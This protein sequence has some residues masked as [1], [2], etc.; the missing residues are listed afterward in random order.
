MDIV[1]QLILP[2]GSVLLLLILGL[3]AR[4]VFT[5][6][7]GNI[8]IAAGLLMLFLLSLWPVAGELARPLQ[9]ILP[10]SQAQ[11]KSS[12]AGAI[13]ILSAGRNRGL[14]YGGE[15]IDETTLA[16]VR[17]GA[18]LYQRSKLPVL[19]T[20]GVVHSR[21]QPLAALMKTALEREFAT[22]V[23]WVEANSNTTYENAL[24]SARILQAANIEHILLVTHAMHMRRSVAAFE[25]MG[26]KVTPAPT[27]YEYMTG[28]PPDQVN[29]Y[30]PNASAL[31]ASTEALHE[32]FG[33]LWYWL[34]Y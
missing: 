5:G 31:N 33:L 12:E 22:P 24:Y 6:W 3:I 29:D 30:F 23:R 18:W 1:E 21:G 14:E 19:V 32:W 15:V 8:M 26:I 27:M 9:N 25:K 34:R 11:L 7:L 13:V 28:F 4:R 17:Y 10:L 20:G 2:P 16:R